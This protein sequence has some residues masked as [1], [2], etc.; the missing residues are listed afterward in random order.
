MLGSERPWGWRFRRRLSSSR[1]ASRSSLR[2]A[3]R[4][5]RTI[6][7][8]AP[9]IDKTRLSHAQHAQIEVRARVTRMGKRPGAD[10]HAPCDDVP[11]A[12]VPR[13]RP[14]SSARSATRR[15][16]RSP[17]AAPLRPYPIED[18]WQAE[19]PRFSHKLHMDF[20]RMEGGVGFHVTCAD[21]HVRDGKLARADHAT[22]S[23]CHAPEAKLG[24]APAMDDCE[25]CHKK[26]L[27]ERTRAAPDQGRPQ[28][29]SR[30]AIAPTA[31]ARR[32]VRGVPR[33]ERELDVVRRP[34]AAARRELRRLPRRLRAR[35]ATSCACAICQTCHTAAHAER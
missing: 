26:G 24:N 14:A 20:A 17:L 1:S 3:A 32:S 30:R 12:G 9:P 28:V 11:Q 34:R 19:P 13:R 35:T 7:T 29:R 8:P 4:Q 6:E 15:S 21:C 5:A 2:S 18:V 23:R 16:R 22:C 33:T 27:H 31:A 10:D 25:G